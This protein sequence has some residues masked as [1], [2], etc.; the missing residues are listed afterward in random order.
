M[1]A[2]LTAKVIFKTHLHP[3]RTHD[4]IEY[5]VNQTTA[6]IHD[7]IIVRFQHKYWFGENLFFFCDEQEREVIFPRP[8]RFLQAGHVYTVTVTY[9]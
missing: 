8:D 5:P 4:P 9:K 3:E 1:A 6:Q 7:D 2:P